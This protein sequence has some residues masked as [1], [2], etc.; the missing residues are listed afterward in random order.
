MNGNTQNRNVCCVVVTYNP[1]DILADVIEAVVPQVG[2]TFIIDNCST[3]PAR[4]P[5]SRL[6]RE[7]PCT[8]TVHS[9]PENRGIASALNIGVGMALKG[10]F[11]WVLTLDQDSVASPGMVGRLLS[12]Y[13]EVKERVPGVVSP[14]HIDQRTG[15][16]YKYVTFGRILFR[17]L[18]PR[19]KPVSCSFCITSGSLIH[20]RVFETVG[21]FREDYFLYAVDNEFCRRVTQSGFHIYVSPHA[22][23]RHR[24]GDRKSF[25]LLLLRID[26]PEWGPH[27]LYYIFRNV[28]FELR[29][30]RR[31]SSR[32]Y[33]ALFLLKTIAAAVLAG[34]EGRN[35]RMTAVRL[36]LA[37][38]LRGTLGKAERY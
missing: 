2:H 12:T 32:V 25:P 20:R 35:E 30:D 34:A 31:L 13:R 27:S 38:G 36:G 22:V 6:E 4:G 7:H 5:L 18:T 14:V 11:E 9:L 19:D 10:G 21:F 28:V 3:L 1:G 16:K 26:S 29:S 17:R 37:D 23:L 33:G 15:K 24:E 8:L